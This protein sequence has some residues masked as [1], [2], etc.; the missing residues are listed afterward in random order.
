MTGLPYLWIHF[1]L[2]SVS[3]HIT[4]FYSGRKPFNLGHLIENSLK[5][6]FPLSLLRRKDNGEGNS[7][8]QVIKSN[9]KTNVEQFL[10]RAVDLDV[11]WFRQPLLPFYQKFPF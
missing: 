4:E 7:T 11:R 5:S 2:M 3:S 9:P 10:S 1:L 6:T 8:S